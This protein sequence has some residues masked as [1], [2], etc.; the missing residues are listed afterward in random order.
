MGIDYNYQNASM[1]KV[2]GKGGGCLTVVLS[3]L[4]IAVLVLVIVC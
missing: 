3:F 2:Y 1:K 4:C